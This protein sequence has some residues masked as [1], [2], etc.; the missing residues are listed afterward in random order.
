MNETPSQFG[1]I[2]SAFTGIPGG[3]FVSAD[4]VHTVRHLIARKR[5]WFDWLA[6]GIMMVATVA[7]MFVNLTANGFA[8]E[9][10]AAA[11]Q[12]GSV[13]WEAFL[14]GSSDAA[15]S[16]TVDKPPAALWL[17]ALSIKAF[18]LNS[19]A[20][21]L[22]EALCGVLSVW[23]LYASVRRYWGNWAGIIAGST[24]ALTPVAALMF[25]F[26]NPDALLVLLMVAASASVL[27][28]LEYDPDRRDNRKRT[29][30]LALAGVC[31][32]LG[33]L[34]K[35]MQVFLVL[36][37]FA[38]AIL[39]ASPTK[40]WRRL[41]DSFVALAA[42][43]VSA[44][45]WVLLTVIVPA[46]SRP[47]IGGSQ[48]NS[49]LELTFGYN[50]FGRLTG[51]ETGSVV[52]G[53][54]GGHAGTHAGAG[55]SAGSKISETLGNAYTAMTGGMAGGPGGVPGVG[56]GQGHGSH[57]QG[58]GMWGTTGI[59]RLFDGVYGTQISWLAPIA[60]AGILI[61]LAVSIRVRR[62]DMRRAGV[63]V[64]GGW[65]AVTWLTFSFMGGIFHQYYTVALAPAVAVMVAVAAQNLWE[66][67][68]ALWSRLLATILVLVST[69]WAAQLLS[70]S[71]WLPWLRPAVLIV[72]I[73]A[74]LALL[75]SAIALLPIRSL[76]ALR[77]GNGGKV[78][79]KIGL[80]GIVLAVVTLYAGPTAWTGYT[81]ATG[82]HGSI[83]T[84]GPEVSGSMGGPGGGHGGRGGFGGQ[85]GPGGGM[86]GGGQ[87]GQRGQGQ[88]SS[89]NRGQ[90]DQ[91]GFGAG[92]SGQNSQNGQNNQGNVNGS[93]DFDGSSSPGTTQ[94][95]SAQ[96]AGPN[97]VPG[98]GSGRSRNRFMNSRNGSNNF[99]GTSGMS[100]K[101]DSG[102][103]GNSTQGSGN[104]NTT[105][106]V[107]NTNGQS[108][109]SG[110]NNGSGNNNGS[111]QTGFGGGRQSGR[112]Q[113]G[114]R[115][116]HGGAG[117]LLGGDGA[118]SVGTKLKKLLMKDAD[119]YTWI[120]AATGSQS[121]SGYQ[122]ATQKP[123]MP[124][125]GFNGS[126]PSPTLAQFK[127]YVK[128][129]RIHYYIGGG[130][131]GGGMGGNQMGGSNASSQIATWVK[132]NFKS[133]TVD[134]VTIYDLTTPKTNK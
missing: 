88:S 103:S 125:G 47:Y 94:G 124:I 126:D 27:R 30:W 22:P 115:N 105:G 36:P 28:A 117:G 100:G 84:A 110:G 64:W 49:F 2:K 41:V 37:G 20:L 51:N 79:N 38:L 134:G 16:I 72:G 112:G 91:G 96:G 78:V 113:R 3:R 24:L 58:G 31:I 60:F 39:I 81:V 21:L 83:V 57:G 109:G 97:S 6:F 70:R 4:P 108:G 42:M 66:R 67:R 55:S 120:A 63:M 80:V 53:G 8:N 85:G 59:T 35:Q 29:L 129:G 95:Q 62:T 68:D 19:F 130:E 15:N 101:P 92:A 9:F 10:Y 32:G 116:G 54:G 104:S 102:S 25:R 89:G 43:V 52:P 123:V 86:P 128:E 5:K 111:G 40:F 75:V 69:L 12:A 13:N 114:T 23:L 77:S 61:G 33:F 17:M 7:I 87:Q 93:N 107:P 14:W 56:G 118:S 127:R 76:H 11:A 82:H 99:D 98:G 121:A 48:N 119:Q 65:L 131:M 74:T 18:G 133:Q 90:Q 71:S 45:W 106:G 34:T 122:L 50:G 132:A 46:G 73:V 26:D 1:R 44:G